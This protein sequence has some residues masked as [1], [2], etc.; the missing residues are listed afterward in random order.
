MFQ[1]KKSITLIVD[2]MKCSGCV[3]RIENVLA[4]SLEISHSTVDLESGKVQIYY[5]QEI[6]V[7]LIVEKIQNLGFQVREV[8]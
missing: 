4:N 6:D 8:I 1:K 3:H 2:G 5:K 7:E